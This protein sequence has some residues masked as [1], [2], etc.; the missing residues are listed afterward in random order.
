MEME[1]LTKERETIS[2]ARV[3]ANERKEQFMIRN[4]RG[5][6]KESM[7]MLKYYEDQQVYMYRARIMNQERDCLLGALTQYARD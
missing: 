5:N 6:L 2:E 3:V 7:E 4:E 1:V